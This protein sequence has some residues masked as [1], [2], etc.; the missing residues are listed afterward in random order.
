MRTVPLIDLSQTH[1]PDPSIAHW[2]RPRVPSDVPALFRRPRDQ[3]TSPGT[4]KVLRR[5]SEVKPSLVLFAVKMGTFQ[6][7][8]QARSSKTHG[9]EFATR[10]RTRHWHDLS[11]QPNPKT[12]PNRI[13]DE[14]ISLTLMFLF[15][16][17]NDLLGVPA[18]CS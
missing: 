9:K 3:M 15:L 10:S 5:P 4:S 7:R 1:P 11:L 8:V 18:K 14:P 16:F 13:S 2:I 6:S 17:F 12:L